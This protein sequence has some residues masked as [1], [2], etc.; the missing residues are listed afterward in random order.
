MPIVDV[1]KLNAAFS[2]IQKAI[3]E[4]TKNEPIEKANIDDNPWSP[5]MVAPKNPAPEIVITNN[6]SDEVAGDKT[7][8]L[9]LKKHLKTQIASLIQTVRKLDEGLT[10]EIAMVN[11]QELLDILSY[12]S[13]IEQECQ[14]CIDTGKA[15]AEVLKK[16]KDKQQS[17]IVDLMSKK[18]LD[19]E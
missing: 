14:H 18:E 5:S 13:F 17:D 19:F 8:T 11:K 15:K 1:S 10:T 16:M 6:D 3:E 4:M 12:M 7:V 9:Q 2:E